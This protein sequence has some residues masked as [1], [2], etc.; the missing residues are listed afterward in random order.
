[1][2]LDSPRQLQDYI[3]TGEPQISDEIQKLKYKEP[4]STKIPQ[5]EQE[6][7][8][9]EAQS[10]VA[11]AQLTNITRKKFREAYAVHLAAVIE[12]AEKQAI[13]AR[14]AQKLLLLLDDSPIVPGENH[15]PFARQEEARMILSDAEGE[16][17][18][19][20]PSWEMPQQTQTGSD[21]MAVPQSATTA[22][23]IDD[24]SD[25]YSDPRQIETEPSVA[26]TTAAEV[27]AP[28]STGTVPET[29][30]VETQHKGVAV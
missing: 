21:G 3:L 24:Q 9:A 27:H 26:D 29:T 8:R 4:T 5:L 18:A 22:S 20:N 7:V 10:L 23:T 13:L 6:L 19:W 1:M 17:K 25:L 14:Q 11:E 16:L 30:P 2:R 15:E 28:T 12:R